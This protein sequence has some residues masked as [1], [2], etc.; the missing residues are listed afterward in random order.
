MTANAKKD[1]MK[2][3]IKLYAKN[4]LLVVQPVMLLNVLNVLLLKD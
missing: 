4:V 3:K 2:L 1:S